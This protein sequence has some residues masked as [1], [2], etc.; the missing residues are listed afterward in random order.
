MCVEQFAEQPGTVPR[1][2]WHGPV[3]QISVDVFPLLCS[4]FM[5]WYIPICL[6]FR[7]FYCNFCICNLETD[8]SH[9]FQFQPKSKLPWPTC[10]ETETETETEHLISAETET[11]HY[12]SQIL[13]IATNQFSNHTKRKGNR[14][15]TNLQFCL[16]FYTQLS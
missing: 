14:I 16:L 6:S 15:Q 7:D 1:T 5:T 11:S 9:F 8:R 10:T 4:T 13:A 3:V 12:S 2:R